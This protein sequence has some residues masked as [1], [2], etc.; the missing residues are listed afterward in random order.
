MVNRP[1]FKLISLA[2]VALVLLCLMPLPSTALG[3]AVGPSVI[4]IEKAVQGNSYE[5]TIFVVNN[6]EEEGYFSFMGSGDIASWITFYS[7]DKGST[8]NKVSV[9]PKTYGYAIAKFTIPQDVSTSVFQG[10][11]LVAGPPVDT[12]KGEGAKVQ[13]Q[14]PIEVVIAIGDADASAIFPTAAPVAVS[15]TVKFTSFNYE[16][17]A[18]SIGGLTKVQAYFE[19]GTREDTRAILKAEVYLKDKLIETLQ[20]EETLVSAGQAGLLTVYFKPLKNGDYRIAGTIQYGDKKIGPEQ[21]GFTVGGSSAATSGL[22]LLWY[23]I[24]VGVVAILATGGFL[25]WTRRASRQH[26]T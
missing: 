15:G 3:L 19:N 8:I 10:K 6:S 26:K 24:P 4:K 13:L 17:K 11:I 1:I 22:T 18:P 21:I 7:L 23:I 9:Q 12:G 5:Q 2:I 20:S 25:V 14:L 16:G